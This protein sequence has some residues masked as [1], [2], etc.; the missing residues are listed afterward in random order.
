VLYAE[1]TYLSKDFYSPY[2]AEV[3]ACASGSSRVLWPF[4]LLLERSSFQ[5]RSTFNE[6][7][8]LNPQHVGGTPL[9]RSVGCGVWSNPSLCQFCSK[10]E[11][12]CGSSSNKVRHAMP[13]V[14]ICA[15]SPR[16]VTRSIRRNLMRFSDVYNNTCQM[17]CFQ[18]HSIIRCDL[19]MFDMFRFLWFYF[20][21]NLIKSH[22]ILNE[23][24]LD[25]I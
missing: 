2:Y 21:S 7:S 25:S 15:D 18:I 14:L 11:L 9:T 4:F 6:R 20:S 23:I 13:F 3:R 24:F 12:C 5:F 1:P 17:K 10:C 22:Q 19:C 16:F 8:T